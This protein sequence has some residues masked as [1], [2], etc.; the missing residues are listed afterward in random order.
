MTL[1]RAKLEQLVD[2]LIQ[3]TLKPVELALKDAGIKAA[4]MD[5]IVMVGGMTRMP[6]VV[7]TVTKFFGKE[8][9]KSVNPDEVVAIGRGNSGGVLAGDVK[10]VLL[11]DVTPLTLGIE[12]MGSVA[13]PLFRET[14]PFPVPNHRYFQPLLIIRPK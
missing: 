5:E 4:D 13:T 10:D 2:S 14:P 8:P 7:E 3:K 12:T 1:T 6:K 9:N 11:L